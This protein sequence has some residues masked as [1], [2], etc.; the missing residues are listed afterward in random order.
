MRHLKVRD[1]TVLSIYHCLFMH[2]SYCYIK[3]SHA[4]FPFGL[5]P[6]HTE[7]ETCSVQLK[8]TVSCS[9]CPTHEEVLRGTSYQRFHKDCNIFPFV[10][11][12]LLFLGFLGWS[13]IRRESYNHC[14]FALTPISC[15]TRNDNKS[16]EMC[17]AHLQHDT[18]E[19]PE[20]W[21]DKDINSCKWSVLL[22]C[23]Q[24]QCRDQGKFKA[25]HCC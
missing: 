24:L 10:R 13:I 15:P 4:F 3:L 20:F 16:R 19:W 6:Q 23:M 11:K 5:L 14:C 12:T 9:F 22:I 18:P 25:I 1:K 8:A 7:W 2:V 17:K 21:A